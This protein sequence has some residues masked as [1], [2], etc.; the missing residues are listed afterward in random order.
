M[1]MAVIFIGG[2]SFGLGTS[3]L[4]YTIALAGYEVRRGIEQA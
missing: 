3:W 4:L 1:D 2:M